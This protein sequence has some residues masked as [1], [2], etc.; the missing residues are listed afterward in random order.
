MSNHRYDY[1]FKLLIIGDPKVGKTEF[2]LKFIDDAFA[3]KFPN[4]HF[5][6]FRI[7]EIKYGNKKIKLQIWDIVDQK[8][9]R[10]TIIS[11]YRGTNGII[12]IYDV[13]DLNS[14]KN[15]KN[16]IKQINANAAKS[17]GKI[18]VGNKSDSPDRVVTEEEGKKLAEE[19]NMDYF[20]ASAKTNKNVNEVF[21]YLVKE[22]V[23]IKGISIEEN[24]NEKNCK[25]V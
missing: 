15:I 9:F 22:I 4:E 7:K 5:L 8:R 24:K 11:Y 3:T 10:Q 19:F 12:L 20:E 6:D 16:W 23:K 21:Y 1:L 18:L 17:I 2:I 25:I 14:F 13:T